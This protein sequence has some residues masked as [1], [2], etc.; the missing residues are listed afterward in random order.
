[1]EFFG[2]SDE[3]ADA[4]TSDDVESPAYDIWP[5]NLQAIRLFLALEN[6]WDIVISP[7]GEM[8]RTG[9]RLPAIESVLRRTNGIPVREWNVLFDKMLWMERPALSEMNKARSARQEKREAEAEQS[10]NN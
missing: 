7:D 5:E 9:M 8:I 6:Q 4:P 1:M 10:R 3:I 2:L